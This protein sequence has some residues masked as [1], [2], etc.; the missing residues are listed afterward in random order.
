MEGSEKELILRARSGSIPDFE[1]LMRL[2]EGGVYGYILRLTGNSPDAEDLTQDTF[3]KIFNALRTYDQERS[4][5]TWAY[6]IATRTVYDFFRKKKVRKELY[7]IDD[8]DSGFETIDESQSYAKIETVEDLGRALLEIK[9]AYKSVLL[10]YYS[11]GFTY[12]EIAQALGKPIN[13]VKT[14]IRRAKQAL[15]EVIEKENAG[16]KAEIRR[17]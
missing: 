2:Y 13:T 4:F 5:K 14:N 9:P 8:E 15:K 7:I 10:L 6:T 1:E 11:E 12:E 16:I 3:L 17:T